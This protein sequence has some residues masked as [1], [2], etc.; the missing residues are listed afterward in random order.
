MSE[1]ERSKTPPAPAQFQAV[2]IKATVPLQ[3][4]LWD[5]LQGKDA[6]GA[7]IWTSTNA[8]ALV[9]EKALTNAREVVAQHERAVQATPGLQ[10]KP[11]QALN[12][13]AKYATLPAAPS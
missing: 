1:A 2:R 5:K 3:H 8:G 12:V 10:L 6:G 7:S 4:F 11:T 13:L 9:T